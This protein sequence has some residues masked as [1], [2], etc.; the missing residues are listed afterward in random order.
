MRSK[1]PVATGRIAAT[2]RSLLEASRLCAIATVT[3]TGQPHLNTEYF[4]W[5]RD[6]QLVWLSE[7]GAQHSR[8]IRAD[9]NASVAVY[10]SEQRWGGPDRGIQLFGTVR[11]LE[12]SPDIEAEQLYGARFPDYRPGGA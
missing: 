9:G 11:E 12:R 4:A 1:R 7:P 10:D 2:A 6:F 5:S 8:N 3:S